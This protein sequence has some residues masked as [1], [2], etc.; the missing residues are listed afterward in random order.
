MNSL[1]N[2]IDLKVL[3]TNNI[4]E[5]LQ[6]R[7]LNNNIYTKI[8]QILLALNPFK[9]VHLH[10]EQ[11]HPNDIALLCLT[12]LKKNHTN[13]SILVSGESGAG[14]TETTKIILKKLL[15]VNENKQNE[16]LLEQ[17]YWSNYILE[18]F[19]N[20]KTIRNHNSSRFGKYINIFY[21]QRGHIVG[22]KIETYL[23][24]KIRVTKKSI[25]ER[26]YHIFYQLFPELINEKI[27]F[28]NNLEDENIDDESSKFE[29]FQAFRYFNIQDKTINQIKTIL[30]IIILF[31]DYNKNKEEISKLMGC[32][33][34]E[35]IEGKTIK[36]GKEEIYKKLSPDEIEIKIETFQQEL[37]QSLFTYLV[38]IINKE[39]SV[40]L[41]TKETYNF[42]GIL[43][44][45]GFEILDKNSIEQLC[46]NYTNEV[47]QNTFN[48]YFFEKEQELYISEGLP[49]NLVSFEN[50]DKI[51]N[52]LEKEIFSTVNEVTK[53]I[54]GSDKQIMEMIF[55]KKDNILEI[56]NL[57]KT[58]MKFN[59]NHYADKVSYNLEEFLEKNKL[60]CPDELKQLLIKSEIKL[61]IKL[62]T[63]KDKLLSSFQK[64]I[65]LLK[66]KIN[67][68]QVNFIR[69]LKP[70][71]EMIPRQLSDKRMIQ[72]LKY[73]GVIEAIRVARQGYP[74]RIKNNIFKNIYG[75]IPRKEI[76]WL[77]QGKT[78]TFLNH[79]QEKILEEKRNIILNHKS[80]LIQKIY[81]GYQLYNKYQLYKK[82]IIILQS[83]IRGRLQ[84]IKYLKLLYN[85][86]V[87]IIRK[88]YL[89][90]KEQNK[91]YKIKFV[92]NWLYFRNH[93]NKIILIK[94]NKASLIISKLFKRFYLLNQWLKLY[95]KIQL[96]KGFIKIIIA[97]KELFTLKKEAK[98]FNK[99]KQ[100]LEKKHQE[101][102]LQLEKQKQ[103][104]L[105]KT[106]LEDEKL[107]EEFNRMM[108]EKEER[109]NKLIEKQK[110]LE[111]QRLVEI[112]KREE[113]NKENDRLVKAI[114]ERDVKFINELSKIQEE[115]DRMRLLLKE[116][117]KPQCSVM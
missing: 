59:I 113:L 40:N 79:E 29:L 43:D 36:V 31:G 46:I 11:P 8:N 15:D 109:E 21:N 33:I 16:K 4:L 19:G 110:E 41:G 9:K 96:I 103:F 23:L 60:N 91:Y 24:E 68:T 5:V 27:L 58:K 76:N 71:D 12:N 67:S 82:K 3:D 86:K 100:D 44:I 50:N 105:E 87:N 78:L 101:L 69:C 66:N 81:R 73:N 115:M 45:F 93:Y 107:K 13:H 102:E 64:Q 52:K 38:E 1:S 20:A 14:K 18:S 22:A 72:Q 117:Q 75:L 35:Y 55:K 94:K 48:K 10:K 37:Y 49:Y 7:Y 62:E 51:I 39:L 95:Q 32:S 34:S 98:D 28:S 88:Y 92:N 111:Y 57:D 97:K 25:D 65:K 85:F 56:S 89:R 70:N 61:D 106:Q 83:F 74:I 112:K 54:K 80:I 17:I 116:K 99:I 108:M 114:G 77:I 30:K 42:I 47:L 90:F 53:F 26:N 2:L 104:N 63:S 84:R 6:E